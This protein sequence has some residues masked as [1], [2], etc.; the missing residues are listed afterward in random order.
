MQTVSRGFLV[1]MSRYRDRKIHRWLTL[2]FVVSLLLNVQSAF[3]CTM[4]SN[5][6]DLPDTPESPH[7]CCLGRHISKAVDASEPAVSDTD[8]CFILKASLQVKGSAETDADPGNDHALVKDK[9]G[10]EDL[11]FSIA[12]LVL[13][14]L[15]VPRNGNLIVPTSAEVHQPPLPIYQATQR[16]RI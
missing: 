12:L 7:E 5:M 3:A 14:V 15:R 9:Q 4:M 13:A 10:L 1:R 16:Y 6:P 11:T 2:L 8:S